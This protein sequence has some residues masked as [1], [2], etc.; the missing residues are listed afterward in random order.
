MGNGESAALE[1]AW[2]VMALAKILR[3]ESADGECDAMVVRGLSA[4]I[5][6]LSSAMIEALDDGNDAA[7]LKRIRGE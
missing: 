2:E 3:R 6:D 1:A 7:I 5:L 4:R